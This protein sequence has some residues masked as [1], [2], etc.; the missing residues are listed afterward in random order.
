MS[1]FTKK[2]SPTARRLRSSPPGRALDRLR[3]KLAG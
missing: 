1:R 2:V 3:V